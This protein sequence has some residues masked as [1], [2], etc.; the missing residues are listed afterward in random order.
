MLAR[1]T[2]SPP[3]RPISAKRTFLFTHHALGCVQLPATTS[4]AT[5]SKITNVY[6]VWV[7]RGALTRN[8]ANVFL[9]M[10]T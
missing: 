8:H 2:P 10:M 1:A 7:M 6:N 5:H 9:V 4:A 3:I